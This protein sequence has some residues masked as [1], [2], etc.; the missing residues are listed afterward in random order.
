[1]SYYIAEVIDGALR[2]RDDPSTS[3]TTLTRMPEGTEVVCDDYNSTWTYTS[4]GMYEGYAMK[5]F[6]NRVANAEFWQWEFG[7]KNLYNG[8]SSSIFVKRAQRMLVHYNCLADPDGTACDG[9]FGDQTEAA[10]RAFQRM[11]NL[12]VDGIIG[13]A[14][15]QAL[16]NTSEW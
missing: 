15:K 10:V 7:L 5:S 6:L 16:D 12:D 14:T 4:Y 2:L 13:P 1:M 11:C 8:C 3:S 9:V